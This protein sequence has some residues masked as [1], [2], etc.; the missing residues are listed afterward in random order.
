MLTAPP[1]S[2]LS[3]TLTLVTTISPIL[4]Y[5]PAKTQYL[6][7]LLPIS[8][9]TVPVQ[10]TKNIPPLALCYSYASALVLLSLT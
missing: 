1:L 7:L 5:D 2:S 8:T 6:A 9:T 4:C 3:S 10:H